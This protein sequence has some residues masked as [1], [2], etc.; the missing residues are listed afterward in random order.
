[1]ASAVR[2]RADDPSAR[3]IG[4]RQFNYQHLLVFRAVVEEGGASAAARRLGLAQATVSEQLQRL[5]ASLGVELFSRVGGRLVLTEAGTRVSRYAQEIAALGDELAASL[6]SEDAGR[7]PRLVVG[8][9]DVVPKL[10][11]S[12]LLRAAFAF[13]ERLRV[14]CVED[15]HDR[16]IAQLALHAV[17]VV[18]TDAPVGSAT[19]VRAYTHDLGG[20]GV[21]FL[22]AAPLAQA[23]ARRFPASL[24]GAPFLLPAEGTNLRRQLQ[25]FFEAQGVRPR[26]RSECA[27]SALLKALGRD[28]LGV[29]AVPTAIERQVLRD[30]DVGVVGRSDALRE[31]YFA[32]TVDRRVRSPVVAAICRDGRAWLE[33]G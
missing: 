31:E 26:V 21:S 29:F 16:L 15:A 10:V 32:I 1:M 18:L 3:P 13:D 4:A 5:E 30:Y 24:D 22:A 11:A 20:C 9:A 17:D 27:D 19:L 12:R 2:K 23:L 8:L 6:D 25:R 14:V 33:S 7:A 28:R